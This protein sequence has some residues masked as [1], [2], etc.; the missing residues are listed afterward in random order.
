MD[1]FSHCFPKSWKRWQTPSNVESLE[2]WFVCSFYQYGCFFHQVPILW[3]TSSYGKWMGFLNILPCHGKGDKTARMEEAWEIGLYA[4]SIVWL[5]FPLDSDPVVYFIIWEMQVFS[6]HFPI[7]WKRQQNHSNGES[8]GNKF[9]H[10][11]HSMIAFY[12]QI[13]ILWY[14]SSYGKCM[15]FPFNFSTKSIVQG[16]TWEIDTH[17]FPI[18]AQYGCFFPIRS[19]SHDIFHHLGNAWVSQLISL[20]IRKSSKLGE[21][22]KLVPILSPKY[23]CFSSIRFTPYG[24]LYHMAKG[25]FS[26]ISNSTENC[27]KTH[28]VNS[29]VVFSHYYFFCFLQ[30]LM[31]HAKNRQ[32]KTDKVSSVFLKKILSRHAGIKSKIY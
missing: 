30:N 24:I 11:C 19:P 7:S 23:G 14:T 27:S 2:N 17:I 26:I 28:S 22:G 4:V 29:Q 31:I 20:G 5:F 15:G 18:F 25:F 8:L 3:Y 6:H 16:R 12:H 13:P 10:F 9:P 32:K 1:G 21:H